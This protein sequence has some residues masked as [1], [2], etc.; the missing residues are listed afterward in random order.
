[1]T[2]RAEFSVALFARSADSE[3]LHNAIMEAI[4]DRDDA[5]LAIYWAEG[6]RRIKAEAD[7]IKQEVAS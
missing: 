2:R 4:Q 3:T 5:K 1:M 6:N 7:R